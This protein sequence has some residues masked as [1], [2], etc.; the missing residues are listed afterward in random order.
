MNAWDALRDCSELQVVSLVYTPSCEIRLYSLCSIDELAQSITS[1]LPLHMITPELF[2][3][4]LRIDQYIATSTLNKENF[5]ANFMKAIE[6]FSF[7]DLQFFRGLPRPINVLVITEDDNLDGMRDVPLIGRLSVE[8]SKLQLR[9][10]RPSAQPE[11]SASIANIIGIADLK[12]EHLPVIVLL[13]HDFELIGAHIQRLP[14]LNEEMNRIC[15]EWIVSHPEIP[16][17]NEPLD[18]MSPITRTR[19]TQAIFAMTLDQKTAW[20]RK[21]VQAWRATLEPKPPPVPNEMPQTTET[22]AREDVKQSVD[23]LA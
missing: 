1:A 5:R 11:Q 2:E 10:F 15:S 12:K 13:T 21:T 3:T 14:E 8:V 4:G 9:L 22:V 17:V 18:K 7:D 23:E 20:A 16:D 6:A 19:L